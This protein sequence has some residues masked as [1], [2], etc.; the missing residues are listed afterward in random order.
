MNFV[1][2]EDK[3]FGIMKGKKKDDIS[4]DGE[5][6]TIFRC[7]VIAPL[8]DFQ[9]HRVPGRRERFTSI[10]FHFPVSVM[11]SQ[12][13]SLK[14]SVSTFKAL[15]CLHLF[16]SRRNSYPPNQFSSNDRFLEGSRATQLKTR[17]LALRCSHT[18][19]FQPNKLGVDM[20]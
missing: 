11:S 9:R 16:I 14:Q 4:R 15:D 10:A 8:S 7:Y 13:F 20:M 19:K 17:F 5:K 6:N 2:M 1:Y 12:F 18:S 3:Q